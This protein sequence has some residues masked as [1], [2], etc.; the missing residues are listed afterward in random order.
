[1]SFQGLQVSR[2]SFAVG[3]QMVT[4]RSGSAGTPAKVGPAPSSVGW[5]GREAGAVI[6]RR[7]LEFGVICLVL[8]WVPWGVLG[9]L[10]VNPDEG[11]GSLVFAL[12][13]SGPSLAALVMWLRYRERRRVVRWSPWCGR[14]LPSYSV[15]CRRSSR[16]R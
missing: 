11:A 5:S 3:R 9:V 7:L 15:H 2:H 13:A 8:T 1:M 12:A 6:K 16:R 4:V 14:S 10:G